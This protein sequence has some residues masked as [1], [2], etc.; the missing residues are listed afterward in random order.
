M[1][2]VRAML[3][4][5]A[6]F[7]RQ[8][9]HRS[10]SWW[11]VKA[12]ATALSVIDVSVHL[13]GVIAGS[14]WGLRSLRPT[15]FLRP[16][17]FLTLAYSKRYRMVF[18]RICSA[19]S[20][21]LLLLIVWV[22]GVYMAACAMMIIYTGHG[23]NETNQA[24]RALEFSDFHNTMMALFFMI[25]GS[26][27]YPDVMLPG[28]LSVNRGITGFLFISFLVRP[29]VLLQLLSPAAPASPARSPLSC[30]CL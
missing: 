30:L 21:I 11:I 19:I 2:C 13:A 1:R 12:G 17:F 16:L 18:Y 6:V 22:V 3:F 26:V 14:S 23:P 24:Q 28:F 10:H 7:W 4:S 27:N 29:H 5:L 25:L 15:R 9:N 8:A 20:G